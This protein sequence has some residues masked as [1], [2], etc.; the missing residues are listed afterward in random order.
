MACVAS[1]RHKF[2]AGLT[3][4]FEQRVDENNSRSGNPIPAA[5]ANMPDQRMKEQDKINKCAKI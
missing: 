3:A 2:P 5:V 4:E 1:C